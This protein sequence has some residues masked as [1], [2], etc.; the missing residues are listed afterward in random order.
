MIVEIRSGII[1]SRWDQVEPWTKNAYGP[2]SR[3][4]FF[5]DIIYKSAYNNSGHINCYWMIL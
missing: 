1:F 3:F 5:R 2:G 4:G